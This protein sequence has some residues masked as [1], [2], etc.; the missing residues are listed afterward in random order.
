MPA[1]HGDRTGGVEVQGGE[2]GKGEDLGIRVR[3]E[4]ELGADRDMAL[5]N[6]LGRAHIE[7]LQRLAAIEPLGELLRG[8]LWQRRV[9]HGW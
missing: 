4:I 6:F 3:V 7:H 2:V 9:R 8:N 5:F 1:D